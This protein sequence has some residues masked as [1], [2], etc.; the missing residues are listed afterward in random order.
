[1]FLVRLTKAKYEFLGSPNGLNIPYEEG[2][3]G[4]KGR[5]VEFNIM[6]QEF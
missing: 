3:G 4:S 5:R 6:K 1:M 2:G